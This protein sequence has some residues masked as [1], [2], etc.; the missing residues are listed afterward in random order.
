MSAHRAWHVADAWGGA[1]EQ[2]SW[3]VERGAA[4]PSAWHLAAWV[5][6]PAAQVDAVDDSRGTCPVPL[7]GTALGKRPL[8]LEAVD[9]ERVSEHQPKHPHLPVRLL[10][11]GRWVWEAG[12]SLQR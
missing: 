7:E 3:I 2:R 10:G 11:G 8:A 5:R 6:L 4:A 12:R 9:D 1:S